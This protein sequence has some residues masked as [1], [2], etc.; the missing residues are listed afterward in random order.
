MYHIIDT[1][2]DVCYSFKE[3]RAK[4]WRIFNLT[5][6]ICID[7]P[8]NECLYKKLSLNAENSGMTKRIQNFSEIYTIDKVS[9]WDQLLNSQLLTIL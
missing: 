1:T 7:T 2:I 9:I 8:F 5:L 6:R 4:L 3:V